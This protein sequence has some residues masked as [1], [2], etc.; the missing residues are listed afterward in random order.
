[1]RFARVKPARPGW[2]H[3]LAVTVFTAGASVVSA[4]PASAPGMADLFGEAL[5][6]N[7]AL[8]GQRLEY[9]ALE[10]DQRAAAGQL[11]PQI[12]ASGEWLNIRRE[13]QTAGSDGND[14]RRFT[15]QTYSLE[16]NQPLLDLP[17]WERWR[18][19]GEAV[20]LGNARLQGQRTT[21]AFD[22]GQRY[23]RT[24]ELA[25]LVSLREREV[26]AVRGS[27]QRAEALFNEGRITRSDL[28]S[29]TARVELALSEYDRTRLEL[30]RAKSRLAALV[31]EVPR[32]LRAPAADDPLPAPHEQPLAQWIERGY[33]DNPSV[34]VRQQQF[35][36]QRREAQVA[37]ARHWPD[38]D[39]TAGYS[40]FD[41]MDDPADLASTSTGERDDLFVGLSIDVPIFSGGS[42]SAE[43][44]AGRLRADGERARLEA[45]RREVQ[46]TIEQ[47]HQAL[48]S[49]ELAI[50]RAETAVESARN[51]LRRIET[52]V[53]AGRSG[54]AALLE[55]ELAL[56][57]TNRRLTRLRFQQLTNALELERD[58]GALDETVLAR[59]DQ[60]LEG[61]VTLP[62][63]EDFTVPP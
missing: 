53:A 50:W 8:R 12:N 51:G 22:I 17:A 21:L 4:Q 40:R 47:T 29:T 60:A 1:M 37:R 34:R 61:T 25:E 31:P 43:A 10:A 15:Q 20:D 14:S 62:G 55:A 2:L 54:Y 63:N 52:E 48:V 18:A 3:A 26:Q 41:D 23:L 42:T 11:L 35:E 27:R 59:F 30:E 13:E 19:R 16:M 39:L 45:L 33:T 9:Q 5:E 46:S 57:A 44:R 6:D 32:S 36:L 7:P 58:G 49:G 38:I 28:D 24:A 56:L